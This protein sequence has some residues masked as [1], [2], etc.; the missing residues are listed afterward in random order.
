MCAYMPRYVFMHFCVWIC[1]VIQNVQ[2]L[3]CFLPALLS[4]HTPA[5]FF[6]P[7]RTKEDYFRVGKVFCRKLYAFLRGFPGD[8]RPLITR[9][10]AL[11]IELLWDPTE[12]PSC[13]SLTAWP[14]TN[15][16]WANLSLLHLS[17]FSLDVTL[18]KAQSGD[19]CHFYPS[20]SV[21]VCKCITIWHD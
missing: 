18:P 6:L 16:L 4:C 17:S 10:L 3:A 12:W 5:T 14:D 8:P 7:L 15:A 11:E 21:L 19:L 1:A 13:S 9:F 2:S 20:I